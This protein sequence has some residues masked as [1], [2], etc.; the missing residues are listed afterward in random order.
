MGDKKA[1]LAGFAR[2]GELLT[3]G[4]TEAD[5]HELARTAE[6]LIAGLDAPN[7]WKPDGGM[8]R[9]TTECLDSL[10]PE[11]NPLCWWGF[12]DPPNAIPAEIQLKDG[13]WLPVTLL[14]L[15]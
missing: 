1:W 7:P 8:Y 5:V 3:E 9:V 15:Q 11:G 6:E 14:V 13:R 10:E 4:L 2:A 12:Q